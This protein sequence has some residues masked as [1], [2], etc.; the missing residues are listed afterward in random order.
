MI[1]D[2]YKAAGLQDGEEQLPEEETP[3]AGTSLVPNLN[4]C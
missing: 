3:A 4:R 2:E 1:L